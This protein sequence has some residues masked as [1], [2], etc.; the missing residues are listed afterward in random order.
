MPFSIDLKTVQQ[1]KQWTF[2]QTEEALHLQTLL[3]RGDRKG[4]IQRLRELNDTHKFTRTQGKVYELFD[5]GEMIQVPIKFQVKKS[6]ITWSF[7]APFDR[8][9][10]SFRDE[11]FN[12]AAKAHA[13]VANSC[14]TYYRG[15]DH[16]HLKEMHSYAEEAFFNHNHY[17]T[18]NGGPITP[19]EV[20]EH[21]FGFYAQQEGRKFI[22]TTWERDNIILTFAVYW[23]NFNADIRY[24]AF[25]FLPHEGGFAQVLHQL[26]EIARIGRLT[27]AQAEKEIDAFFDSEHGKNMLH[28]AKNHDFPNIETIK[29]F[30]KSNYRELYKK[31]APAIELEIAS[32]TSMEPYAIA[33]TPTSTSSSRRSSPRDEYLAGP[34]QAFDEIDHLEY[35]TFA[36]DLTKHCQSVRKELLQDLDLADFRKGLMLYY[37]LCTAQKCAL[38][39]PNDKGIRFHEDFLTNEL[40]EQMLDELPCLKPGASS[41][42]G[43]DSLQKLVTWIKEAPPELEAWINWVRVNGSRGL[44]AEIGG[45]RSKTGQVDISQAIPKEDRK[46]SDNVAEIDFEKVDLRE[47]F[48][49]RSHSSKDET[50]ESL[51]DTNAEE[52]M[53]QLN[54]YLQDIV[55]QRLVSSSQPI[56]PFKAKVQI[57]ELALS[58]LKGK[59]DVKKLIILASSQVEWEATPP[60][61]K[62][63]LESLI[64]EVIRFK[65]PT[66]RD[67][68]VVHTRL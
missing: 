3:Q 6:V 39:Y 43:S 46:A 44:G 60:G 2:K 40:I 36:R 49:P 42:P 26:K 4:Y 31:F 56:E 7:I 23:A 9:H 57:V 63:K 50:E 30:I 48:S 45:V 1:T 29:A 33:S 32:N 20:Y 14:E 37:A 18:A 25:S 66:P 27:P 11:V 13:C 34:D 52:L 54:R 47:V 62:N 38:A 58:V 64:R 15:T 65:S 8:T 24:V 53:S 41:L 5:E 10:Q 68:L 19:V 16:L 61:F 67:E 21:L 17:R 12:T 35:E 59:E 22:P 28:L 51:I 55:K